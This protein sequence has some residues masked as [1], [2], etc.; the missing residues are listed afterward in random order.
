MAPQ[1]SNDLNLLLSA[2]VVKLKVKL[3]A[4]GSK[5]PTQVNAISKLLEEKPV[6][7]KVK[8]DAS[9]GALNKQLSTLGT[10][11]ANSKT[12]KPM[13]ISVEI[14][15]KGSAQ[16]IKGQ[17]QEITKVVED[18]NKKYGEQV[19]K[20][21]EANKKANGTMATGINVP[22]TA[23][24]TN[25]NNIKQY[26]SQL[27]EA[28][29]IMKSKHNDGKGLFS[30][31][32]MKDAKG[33]LTG[34]IATL[35]RANGVVEKARYS[36]NKDKGAFQ[37]V[38][39]SVATATEKMVH[40]Q[41]QALQGLQ[42]ELA[43][44]GAKSKE[45]TKD[46]NK[47]MSE[48]G[49]GNLTADSVNALKT[50][51]SLAQSEY[52]QSLKVNQ[53][54]REEKKL[55]DDI[56]NAIKG[57]GK[58]FSGDASKLL[59]D[60]K[61][62][63]GS[64]EA[65]KD[66]RVELG[67]LV[68]Q[69]S[70]YKKSQSEATTVDKKRT[71]AMKELTAFSR[72][73]SETEGAL[74]ASYIRTTRD[75]ASRARTT[76]QMIE[77]EKRLIAMRKQEA[78]IKDQNARQAELQKLKKA[79][80][81]YATA[82]NTSAKT[83]EARFAQLKQSVGGN[84]GAIG[85]QI[86]YYA[87]KTQ[88]LKDTGAINQAERAFR[89]LVEESGKYNN[90]ELRKKI[91]AG[92]LSDIKKY[93]GEW[94]KLNI[95]TAKIN[96][97]NKGVTTIT[98]QL[99]STG[100][101]V[102]NVI[103][104]V[105]ALTGKLKRMGTTET[106]NPN[107]NLGIFEQ[108]K[109]AMA[110]VPVW[111]ASMTA[112][113]G[114][115]RGVKKV[116][117]EVLAI[118]KVMT[119][120]KRVSSNDV[121]ID[122]LFQGAVTLSK[123]LGNNIH[124]ILGGLE[125]FSR[126]FGEFNER[127]LLAI[128]KT[129]V[130]MSNV[131]DL[132]VQEAQESMVG[133]MNAFNIQASDT[134]R[135]V[136]SM[137]QV[138]ND[139]AISTKQLATG[140]QK[141]SSTAKTFGVSLEEAEG[142]ITAIGSVTMESG[143]IIGN[144]LKTVYSRITT[145][146][147]AQEALAEVGV[148]INE[149]KDG[150]EQVKPVQQ[151]LAD[152]ATKWDTISDAQ[153]QNISV[154]VA[155]RYQLSR[156][157]A[158]M[159]SWDVAVSATETALKS[160]GSAIRENA[161]YMDSFEARINKLKN[162][163][164]ELAVKIG[165]KIMESSLL[166]II[167]MLSKLAEGAM[168]VV[169][170]FG[171]LP[172]VLG[173]ISLIM[174]KMGLFNKQ[175]GTM[176][177]RGI[178]MKN[179][180]LEASA[181]ANVLTRSLAGLRA[182]L[183]STTTAT[184]G[185]TTAMGRF[186]KSFRAIGSATIYLAGFFVL[187]AI[188]EKIISSVAKQKKITEQIA[189]NNKT[190]VNSYRNTEGGLD[191]LADEQDKLQDRFDSGAIKEGTEEYA[192]YIEV[193]NKLAEKLPSVVKYV[194]QAGLAHLKNADAIKK[195]IGFAQKL[196]ELEAEKSKKTFDSTL[197]KRLKDIRK[198]EKEI[199]NA[200]DQIKKLN[201]SMGE[202]YTHRDAYSGELIK[203]GKTNAEQNTKQIQ[204]WNLDIINSEMSKQEAIQ[205]TL[206]LVSET[207]TAYL[208]SNKDL[209]Y[210]S[211][212][213]RKAIENMVQQNETLLRQV[214]WKDQT[215]IST[216]VMEVRANKLLDIS[217]SLGEAMSHTYQEMSKDVDDPLE[218][219]RITTNMDY[220]VK[221]LPKTFFK[222]DD[223]GNVTQAGDVLI[224]KFEGVLSLSN[225]IQDGAKNYDELVQQF[226]DLG[227]TEQGEAEK[228]VANIGYQYDNTA[229]KAKALAQAQ[230]EGTDTVAEQLDMV[231]QTVDAYSQMFGY[232]DES[233]SAI[234]SHLDVLQTMSMAMG[235]NAK[236]TEEYKSSLEG[237]SVELGVSE[238]SVEKNMPKIRRMLELLTTIKTEYKDGVAIGFDYE[239]L[240]K[241]QIKEFEE[242]LKLFD[243][244]GGEWDIVAGA[245]IEKEMA[246]EKA[247]KDKNAEIE[248]TNKLHNEVPKTK[249]RE[250]DSGVSN[251]QAEEAEKTKQKVDEATS[252][253]E[254]LNRSM[255]ETKQ[256]QIFGDTTLEPTTK[257]VDTAWD[258]MDKLNR[259]A[260]EIRQA[261]L[262]NTDDNSGEVTN[263]K[264][265]KVGRSVAEVNNKIYNLKQR[266]LFNTEDSSHVPV[267]EK[268]NTVRQTA[269]E[270]ENKFHELKQQTIFNQED[271]S[272]E[273]TT[274]KI[275]KVKDAITTTSKAFSD[276]K[277]KQLFENDPDNNPTGAVEE[278]VNAL[279]IAIAKAGSS[280]ELLNN[281]NSMVASSKT[282]AVELLDVFKNIA[283]GMDN[284]SNK[285]GVFN[286]ISETVK[287]LAGGLMISQEKM[288]GF[289]NGV[290]EKAQIAVEPLQRVRSAINK[291][292]DSASNV[293][294]NVSN[295]SGALSSI[296]SANVTS[297]SDY[298]RAVGLLSN[299][300][301]F[302]LSYSEKV[303]GSQATVIKSFADIV[304]NT[305]SYTSTIIGFSSALEQA[306]GTMASAISTYTA[307]MQQAY[308]DNATA[309]HAMQQ[310]AENS[311][312]GISTSVDTASIRAIS[313]MDTMTTQ[314]Q[315]SFKEGIEGIV[316]VAG[317]LPKQI[318]DAIRTNMSS[319][320]N[321][322]DDL[323]KDMVKRFK[324]ELG[325]H[326]PSRVF[327]KLGGHV[328]EGLTQGLSGGNLKSLGQSVFKDFGGGAFS[329]LE[330]IKSFLTGDFGMGKVGGGV[331]QWAGVATKALMMEGQ[332]SKANLQRLLYQ[333]QTESGG[334]PR[335]INLWDSNAKKGTPSKGLLQ[336]IDPTYQRYKHPQFNKGPYDPMSNI[337]ASI[338]YAMS[339]YGSLARAYR[340]VG[341]AEGGFVDKKELAWHGEEG[342]EAIIPL[343]PK[344][345]KRGL[346]LWEE[347]GNKLGINPAI[348]GY[349]KK[350][351][352][353]SGGSG[354]SAGSFGASSGESS[355]TSGGSDSGSSGTMI[356]STYQ[357][358]Q[359]LL[360]TP[361]I[362]GA[363]NLDGG[364]DFHALATSS[365]SA[366][367]KSSSSSSSASAKKKEAERKKAEAKR[368]AEEAKRKAEENKPDELYRIDKFERKTKAY[369]AQLA[370]LDARMNS[371]AKSNIAYR[372]TLKSIIAIEN[373]KMKSDVIEQQ[374]LETR[375]KAIEKR[376]NSKELKDTKKHNKKQREEY[377][378]LQEEYDNNTEKINGLKSTVA[379]TAQEIRDKNLEIFNDFVDEVVS[380]FDK[381]IDK[382]KA[383]IDNTEFRI[384]VLSFTDPDNKKALLTE[385]TTLAK[386]RQEEVA[387]N[388]KKSDEALKL[389]NNEKKK[390]D[391]NSKKQEKLQKDYDKEVK[392]NGTK[393]KK[394]ISIKK[395]LDYT[396]A[397]NVDSGARIA[398]LKEEYEKTRE[399]N[400]DSVL[401]LLQAEKD[402][403]DTRLQIAEDA[404]TKLKDFYD[405]M[406]SIA[407]NAIEAEKD[408]V[409]KAHDK[410]MKMYDDEVNGINAIYDARIRAIDKTREEENYTDDLNEKN[411]RKSELT[412]KIALLTRNNTAVD[413]KKASELQEE[414]DALNK[415]INDTQ[416]T[417]QDDM[418]KE[419][420]EAQK[421]AKIDEINGYTDVEGKYH[422]GKRDIEQ[423]ALD[424]RLEA[425][426]IE[427]K[428]VE[429][430]Y[431]ALI[432]NEAHWAQIRADAI[433]GN[434][435]LLE[436]DLRNMDVVLQEINNGMFGNLITGFDSFSQ[437]V[438][439]T[440]DE[441]NQYIIDNL[442]SD[443]GGSLTDV[444]GAGKAPAYKYTNGKVSSGVGTNV[445]T[446]KV[447]TP[448]PTPS[449]SST[450]PKSSTPSPT[451]TKDT[452]YTVKKGDTFWDIENALKLS[453]GTLAK[454][455]PSVNP[456]KL[457]IGSKLL[458]KKGST[459]S[460]STPAPSS[461]SSSQRKITSA[462]SFRSSP[463][464]GNNIIS[465]LP[466]DAKV[467]YVGMEKGWAKV[468][469]N[470]KTGYVG[471]SFLKK[472]K[473]G[474]YT[475][476]K[477]P[478]EGAVAILHNKELVLNE[479][480]TS[481]MLDMAK[482]MKSVMHLMPKVTN[483][484]TGLANQLASQGGVT[485]ITN[486][487]TYE[488][489]VNINGVAGDK[490]IGKVVSNHIM[491]DLKK[492]GKGRTRG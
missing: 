13:K 238:D 370:K 72:T 431:D 455:N 260:N 127:Q 189:K 427:K 92:D 333:M 141:A 191:K 294:G 215:E 277:Q 292:G 10:T 468:K 20:M 131:S 237:I 88:K 201:D 244:T 17:L 487:E 349:L 38:D 330:D 252:S 210:L 470:G 3:D 16:K 484:S 413:R 249:L 377:N 264:V 179:A 44:T 256:K 251:K 297:M 37:V 100:K 89:S 426:D 424:A 440:I 368:K 432:N 178:A 390:R 219:E 250:V 9:I 80:I 448:A 300:L 280:L 79:M 155:G 97:N 70:D 273:A 444:T 369:E 384:Q 475:G 456:N 476:N 450:P 185:A 362:L 184:N 239:G 329:S 48:G 375:Q 396:K 400:E 159:N 105:D 109:V 47:L 269:T 149:M 143:N 306:Y 465:T 145:I 309:L 478:K 73:H 479:G 328:I 246:Q 170:N 443:V 34:F 379:S 90:K 445:S 19:K 222:V 168:T 203:S 429:S 477:V 299:N 211:D 76:T 395:D 457:A 202:E 96:T 346:E 492:M 166:V 135:I 30:S 18:F 243:K 290:A 345:R 14:D 454:L 151:I 423:K 417:R 248:R 315:K 282:K 430:H 114:S 74:S 158:M 1:G 438:K 366:S 389:Y 462:V 267:K 115:I 398:R 200:K 55:R 235:D 406:K 61:N 75:M 152:L 67:R 208:E 422:D 452:Y 312:N 407:V 5:L 373:S 181:G 57:T 136:D 491:N 317:T 401:A 175:M 41:M 361:Q 467:D 458:V 95:A 150:V 310:S 320:T 173:V 59:T 387:T 43:K 146:G 258:S 118:D 186:W 21:S 332:Y 209:Q 53:A 214:D 382:I 220:L 388:Q 103:Y 204:R 183:A 213:G 116:M 394:A 212:T 461:S 262:F 314:M 419:Q 268:L 4:N 78:G 195:E 119:N 93:L 233:T 33:N 486:N 283:S 132:T 192:R 142:H 352:G 177:L 291:I 196:S 35:E 68:T 331:Q 226:R 104:Q 313:A 433:N 45:L 381:A 469:Y 206:M 324:S 372:D 167:E 287:N 230:A 188:I 198:E 293:I 278:K 364:Y 303:M 157:L 122:A 69:V 52:Q 410:K 42:G 27:K 102:K 156:F 482:V 39:R 28:E 240:T 257:K 271:A 49:K 439:D 397:K 374:R 128:T 348:I 101:T 126:T 199:K 446:P 108:L 409:Q 148:N 367:K 60:V 234:L 137:N 380:N 144:S 190:L 180:F 8:L 378:K 363:M 51:I 71:K 270:I 308:S 437:E 259:K 357:I 383:R 65:Y 138:D 304:A 242:G 301:G 229:I 91:T 176:T 365:S 110:R 117:D 403:K 480:Q 341:Y 29:K 323:A 24:V 7:L 22:T 56:K 415:D 36:F 441:I 399:D 130:L 255:F 418:L 319:A 435:K 420:L 99:E 425:L 481:D 123:E 26:V 463:A 327:A 154:Q 347:T 428:A 134:M 81:D 322:M 245:I 295:L 351:M 153:R 163:F 162:A 6:K 402:I 64:L 113:Y 2:K 266:T 83:I 254:K 193:T 385:Q 140:M 436:T 416:R 86:D 335:A 342:E 66:I 376:L 12:F 161:K 286:T 421:Q 296:G 46:F 302:A 232:T 356:P 165:D 231:L 169:D 54:L 488:L 236:K 305:Q 326:S 98:A 77:V 221:S 87:S 241:K 50:K 227:Y 434:F 371:L 160:Q 354:G 405:K 275:N 355:S 224:D 337:L 472:F 289:F 334:N 489:T 274:T 473:S 391:D 111:M 107:R 263:E 23:P 451:T 490:N 40:K 121:N 460:G 223:I 164:T 174:Y 216:D 253:V 485:N 32:E 483:N 321:S 187:G 265:N 63:K 459:S 15:V 442:L 386:Q 147:K 276:L 82:S 340:G 182:G 449:K 298:A 288:G 453:H 106:F 411:K 474:G 129:A 58:N 350:F 336:T 393:S 466:K 412:N 338:R 25:F 339:R 62:A 225:K 84:L 272:A 408:A 31:F 172:I 414:L 139:Y 358:P 11:L 120:I 325:I 125:E 307:K 392:K 112:F 197:S 94:E 360:E 344:R 285:T 316:S 311:L 247:I 228:I 359:A 284:V 85:K 207:S 194:D 318:G 205:K 471:E 133:I 218:L 464:Y 261:K 171:V 353:S 217:N 281:L 279:T 343:I 124:D 447:T 404:I